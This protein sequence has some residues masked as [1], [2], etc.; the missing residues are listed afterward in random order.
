MT[1]TTVASGA[2][3]CGSFESAER[4]SS[5]SIYSRA[6]TTPAI[7]S[8]ARIMLLLWKSTL[9]IFRTARAGTE[10]LIKLSVLEGQGNSTRVVFMCPFEASAFENG[11]Q[12]GSTILNWSAQKVRVFKSFGEYRDAISRVCSCSWADFRANKR[13]HGDI[14]QFD[15]ID[16]TTG[17]SSE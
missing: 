5:L 1:G 9:R 14:G 10:L 6:R 13:S 3:S 7:Y 2:T 15:K 17:A 4:T 16:S 11:R 12:S 8:A